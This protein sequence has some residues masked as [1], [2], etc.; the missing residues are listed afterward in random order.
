[1]YRHH[2]RGPAL[3]SPEAVVGSFVAMQAQEFLPAKW[4]VAQRTAATTNAAM[5][6]AQPVRD[7]TTVLSLASDPTRRTGRSSDAGKINS[8]V[9]HSCLA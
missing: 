7:R 9:T 1:M 8:G 2:L 6:T 4:S 3:G 5:N